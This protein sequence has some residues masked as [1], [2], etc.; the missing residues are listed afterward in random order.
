MTG[1]VKNIIPEK[2]FGFIKAGQE[3]FFFHRDE[4]PYFD[5]LK[6]GDK[7]EFDP[8]AGKR[9]PRAFSVRAVE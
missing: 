8:K 7:V 6:V 3:E 2:G 9:G 5:D 1:T 4:N